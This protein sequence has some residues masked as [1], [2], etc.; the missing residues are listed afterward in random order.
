MYQMNSRERVGRASERQDGAERVTELLT[1]VLKWEAT[2]VA[3][4]GE[5]LVEIDRLFVS[6]RF[7][8]VIMTVVVVVSVMERCH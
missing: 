4:G 1:H 6:N 3:V 2:E 7:L 8:A 5:C